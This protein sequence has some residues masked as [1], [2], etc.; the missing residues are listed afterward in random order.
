MVGSLFSRIRSRRARRLINLVQESN[1]RLN[2]TSMID[3][4][5]SCEDEWELLNEYNKR[6]HEIYRERDYLYSWS[7]DHAMINLWFE[8]AIKRNML[9]YIGFRKEFIGHGYKTP[10]KVSDN[11]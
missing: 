6:V 9:A 4:Y 3:V 10:N 11:C 1:S 7:K 8:R 5:S 2:A